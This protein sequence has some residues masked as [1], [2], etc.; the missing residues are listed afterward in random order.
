MNEGQSKMYV[1]GPWV[2]GSKQK[3]NEHEHNTKTMQ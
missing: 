1:R 2:R 3:N